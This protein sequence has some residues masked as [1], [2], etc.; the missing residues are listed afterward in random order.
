MSDGLNKVM[1]LGNVGHD[2]ELRVVA[3]GDSVL[4]IRLATSESWL[5]K[6][7]VRQQK[8]EWHRVVVWGKR[9]ESLSK[10]LSKGSKI[11]VEGRLQTK[12]YDKNGEKR[13]STEVSAEDIIL[14]GGGPG[15]G[16]AQQPDPTPD[17]GPLPGSDDDIPF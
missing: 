16:Q 8:T 13:Y 10:L 2:P 9:A 4:V 17:T 6:D 5:D 1:L 7:R 14:C 11:H 15:R 3:S 12:S